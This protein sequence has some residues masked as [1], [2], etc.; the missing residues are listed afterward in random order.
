MSLS[1]NILPELVGE[2]IYKVIWT[3]F[4]TSTTFFIRGHGKAV[5]T[6]IERYRLA[7]GIRPG[8]PLNSD[9]YFKIHGP[10]PRSEKACHVA[11]LGISGMSKIFNCYGLDWKVEIHEHPDIGNCVKVT[12]DTQKGYHVFIR[13]PLKACTFNKCNGN[14]KCNF[15][16]PSGY[17]APVKKIDDAPVPVSADA[18]AGADEVDEIDSGAA[19]P[20][21]IEV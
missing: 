21:R 8:G 14:P 17:F 19:A 3:E 11:G 18:A 12:V 7:N 15:D 20:D 10:V 13:K 4:G 6:F 9:R 16:H 2:N 1:K 5:D